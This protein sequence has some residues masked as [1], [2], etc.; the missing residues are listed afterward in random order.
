MDKRR[1][2]KKRVLALLL[3]AL[4]LL[5]ACSGGKEPDA[6]ETPNAAQSGQTQQSAAQK[7]QIDPA[8]MKG[9]GLE[10]LRAEIS[11]AVETAAETTE[12]RE[13][14]TE[15]QKAESVTL[16]FYMIG[17]DL[18]T[19]SGAA[20]ADIA[21]ICGARD[22]DSL[23]ILMEAGGAYDWSNPAIRDEQTARYRIENGRVH[24]VSRVNAKTMTEAQVLRDFLV[25]GATAYPADRYM[26]ILWDHGGG[27]L[28]GFGYD[29]I[30]DG[31][32]ITLP[33]LASAVSGSGLEFDLVGF[34]A[35]LMATLETV[36][37]L[38]QNAD[39]LLAS[40]EFE[41]ASGWNYT[42]AINALAAD[43]ALPTEDFARILID[44]FADENDWD[45]V[46]LSLTD[47][48]YADRLRN[49]YE[50]WLEGFTTT[51]D[52]DAETFAPL[53]VARN[54][55]IE[56]ADYSIDQIDLGD[57][58]SRTEGAG[59]DALLAVLKDA[60]VYQRDAAFDN[61]LSGLAVYFPY[62]STY[63]YE[64][65]RGDLLSLGYDRSV[66]VYD[67]ILSMMEGAGEGD[68]DYYGA[69][70]Y[71]EDYAGLG[72][73]Y[74]Y[75]DYELYLN[76]NENG[77]Y[78]LR[79]TDEEYDNILDTELAVMLELEDGTF[80]DLGSDN[81]IT[82]D[83]DHNMIVS[84]D[85]TWISIDGI[86]IQFFPYFTQSDDAGNTIFSGYCYALLN[87]ETPI[88]LE[89]EWE[90]L[91]D[92]LINSE[93]GYSL[94]GF[95]KGYRPVYENTTA[96][97]KGL[98]ELKRDDTLTFLYDWYDE[99]WN[100]IDTDAFFDP[101][102]VTSQEELEVDYADLSGFTVHYWGVLYDVYQQMYETETV[103]QTI[104]D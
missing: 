94:K 16:L 32:S 49:A 46:S 1:K 42:R 85:G 3:A 80:L 77:D 75:T 68:S 82:W 33:D 40:E 96:Y 44:D 63:L 60:V 79:L 30:E 100:Y 50:T 37:A 90:P 45:F 11:R 8:A 26:L 28:G 4:M 59:T 15:T 52:S 99:D 22:S 21:E 64:E 61:S 7:P 66:A 83:D 9:S 5:P 23:Q 91:T 47:L 43:P 56:F 24:E 35:C 36:S 76:E 70:W 88:Q 13:H 48:S 57:F 18:E 54:D 55:A 65:V 34:D 104:P 25:W 62:R 98:M 103:I 71:D 72:S 84:F 38:S 17:S 39:Y 86:P 53:S 74:S 31:G 97:G 41:P 73:E 89:L 19:Y 81:V 51:I 101:I 95:I 27:T 93:E 20:S 102:T 58:A 67:S 12:V 10:E 78:V 87:G 92:E 2:T 6:P 29:E 14:L 69:D